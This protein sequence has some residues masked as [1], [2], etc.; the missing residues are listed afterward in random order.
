[1][2]SP[3]LIRRSPRPQR[4]AKS[5]ADAYLAAARLCAS[6]LKAANQNGG[7]GAIEFIRVRFF[8]ARQTLRHRKRIRCPWAPS[9]MGCAEAVWTITPG[10]R[11]GWPDYAAGQLLAEARITRPPIPR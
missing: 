11:Y 7:L 1:M 9:R 10:A 6:R 8:T 4:Q 5:P 2:P 3:A